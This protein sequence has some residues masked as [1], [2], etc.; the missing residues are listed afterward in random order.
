MFTSEMNIDL[1]GGETIVTPLGAVDAVAIKVNPDG[2][3]LWSHVIGTSGIDEINKIACS[4]NGEIAVGGQVNG[5]VNPFFESDIYMVLLQ[6]DGSTIWDYNF[7][8]FEQNNSI[9]AL[10]FGSDGA[11]LYVGGRIQ[12]TTQFDPSDM[13]NP[14]DPLFTDPFFAKYSLSD[15]SLIWAQYI[16]SNGIEDY[17]SG[18]AE[19]G[20][21]LMV[22][23]SFDVFA[24]FNPE[25]FQSQIASNGAQDIY[26]AA[27]DRMTGA[28]LSAETAGGPG[29]E[30]ADDAIFDGQGELNLT[31]FYSASL[32]LDPDAPAIPAVGFNDIFVASF[33]YDT[34]L[35]A[36]EI[37][38][39][40]FVSIYPIPTSE[41]L[42]ITH[43]DSFQGAIKIDV[44]NIV[45][46]VVMSINADNL[47]SSIKLD[48]ST[49]NSGLYILDITLGENRF[50]ERFVKN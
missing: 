28:Y 24:R 34:S 38:L 16:E 2:A 17:L 42:F 5:F 20:S 10:L 1:F 46:Q 45:G 14:I 39:N 32:M 3:Y 35:S 21:A 13:A 30:H 4:E 9:S 44:I 7:D 15:G 26:I 25:D 22:A 37:D 31:G 50:S 41:T 23:G 48:V 43:G 18:F 29:N 33:L 8:N 6:S 49:L 47:G 40:E 36:T 19:A 27:Y 11:S 12:G